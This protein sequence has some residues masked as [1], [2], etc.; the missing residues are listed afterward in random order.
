MKMKAAILVQQ[1][2]PL[3]LDEVE[4]PD[5]LEYG[6]VK[7]TIHYSGICGAQ[8]GEIDGVKGEDK[9][10]PHLLGHEGS[11]VVEEVGPGVKT[12]HPGDHVVLHWKRGSGIESAVPLYRWR[13][14]PLNAGWVT[15]FNEYAV[16][17]ENRVTT[18]PESMDMEQAVLFG[19]AVT[20]GL[21]VISNNAQLTIGE[22]IIVFGT[23]GVGLS[24]I[25]GA[26]MVSAHPI[27]GIDLFDHKLALAEKLG[28][29]HVLNAQK[30]DTV[31]GILEILGEAGADV[32]VDTTGNVDVIEKA[33]ELTKP[34]GRTILVGVPKV[35][36]KASLYSL[37]LHFGKKITGS[38]GGDTRPETDIPR[39][40]ALRDAGKLD[41][42]ALITERMTLDDVNT[43]IQKIRDGKVTGRCVM[44][45]A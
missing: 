36:H 7:V 2:K 11:G 26:E 40:L 6:Q 27:I 16:V 28:A 38:H 39:Y 24:I 33:Y 3:V 13:G 14:K 22:S 42:D 30:V 12:V 35:G 37:P 44:K 9:F 23:G 32:A 5:T 41:L 17:A 25:Q 45:I 1:N 8:I 4:L 29:T 19:C 18:I 31:K 10:L 15:T 20:T 21:G 43:A 34:Q